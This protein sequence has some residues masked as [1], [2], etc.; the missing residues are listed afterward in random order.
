MKEERTM[1][2]AYDAWLKQE[3][4]NLK[5]RYGQAR[6]RCT[7]LALLMV[8]LILINLIMLLDEVS[9]GEFNVTS[10][11]A[12]VFGIVVIIVIS[13]LGNY[14][15]RFLKPLL[16][17]IDKELPSDEARQEFARQVSAD[18]VRISYQPRP[19]T[20]SCD[21]VAG[22]HYCYALQ[23]G[24]SRVFKNSEIRRVVLAHEQYSTGTLY[25]LHVRLT[26]ALAL[27]AADQG[28]KPIWKGCFISE[29][30][31]YQ[32]FAL[33]KPRLPQEIVVE[34]DVAAGKQE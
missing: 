19:Q 7:F 33:L 3:K 17:S 8:P 34:D 4:A 20:K 28:Q 1:P 14:R 9:L 6:V 27:Y 26:H 10:L 2:D 12:C 21:L 22:E 29:Q 30:K 5:E 16:A 15:K 13:S 31:L 24:K 25:H 18:A 11:I 32:A 23:P